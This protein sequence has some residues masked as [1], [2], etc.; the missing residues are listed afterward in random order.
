MKINKENLALIVSTIVLFSIFA[1]S[2]YNVLTPRRYVWEGRVFDVTQGSTVTVIQSY[3][4]G[5]LS[6]RG[7]Y[8]IEVGSI[9]KITYISTRSNFAEEIISIEKIG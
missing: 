6:L 1:I 2:F 5:R 3:G 9:Y 7:N 8:T 4:A